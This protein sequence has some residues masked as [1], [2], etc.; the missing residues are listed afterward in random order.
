MPNKIDYQQLANN[1]KHW[2]AELGFSHVGI[3]DTNLSH[4]KNYFQSWLKNN[5]YGDMNYM[6]DNQE[7]RL[8]PEKLLPETLRVISVSM[9]YYSENKNSAIS[10]HAKGKDYHKLIRKRLQKLA[11]K[12]SETTGPIIY[13][14]FTD[15]APVLEKAL[16]E[17]AGIGWIGK[18]T[19]LINEQHGSWCFLGE[20]FINL[21]LPV[22]EPSKN[23]CGDCQKCLDACPTNALIAPFTLDARKCI[24]YITIEH[25]NSIPENLQSLIGKQIFGCDICQKVCPWNKEPIE[26]NEDAFRSNKILNKST[27]DEM[28]SWTEKEFV[29][30]TKGS[31]IQRLGYE[32]WRKSVSDITK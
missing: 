32:K 16:A 8:H 21:P 28:Q 22:D 25:K 29:E 9:N 3:T 7:K 14:A 27:L 19:T 18:N 2:A 12:I 11:N 1:I 26:T 4:H 31:D 10:Q 15:S 6:Q 30:N 23:Q 24:S 5:F 17:K 20:L 13:R